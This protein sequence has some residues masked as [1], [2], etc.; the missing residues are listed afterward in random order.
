MSSSYEFYGIWSL[1]GL[2]LGHVSGVTVRCPGDMVVGET[3]ALFWAAVGASGAVSRAS[4]PASIPVGETPALFWASLL[5]SG[6]Y[7]R[8]YQCGRLQLC[9][10]LAQG[11]ISPLCCPGLAGLT[12]W[13]LN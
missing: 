12:S 3:P 2:A 10:G 9:S 5:G 8:L 1:R 13:L 4:V 7:K 11:R 6:G